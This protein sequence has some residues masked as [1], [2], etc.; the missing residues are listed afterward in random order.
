MLVTYE[1]LGPDN[2]VVSVFGELGKEEAPELT[3]Q[4]LSFVDMGFHRTLL[5]MSRCRLLDW[6]GLDVLLDGAR[7]ADGREVG[8][9][10][11]TRELRRILEATG[12]SVAL[13]IYA[14][15]EEATERALA[16]A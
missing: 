15:R 3:D 6:S 2:L 13:P 11:P 1:V 12:L 5:D 16:V 8:I 14:S 7:H 9:V 10:A 4:L